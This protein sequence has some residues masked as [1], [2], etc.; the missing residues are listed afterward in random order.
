MK[1]ESQ[2]IEFYFRSSSDTTALLGDLIDDINTYTKKMNEA[3]S[4]DNT[5]KALT[6]I[7]SITEK[8]D[9]AQK[10]FKKAESVSTKLNL[11]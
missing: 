2:I 11:K 4:Q 7:N 8:A 3:L 10:L 1:T 9:I 6:Y 5:S